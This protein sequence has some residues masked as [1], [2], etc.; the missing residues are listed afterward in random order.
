MAAGRRL[1]I[2]GDGAGRA[3]AVHGRWLD[4]DAARPDFVIAD[5]TQ[6][7]E[8]DEARI[9]AR[10]RARYGTA[11]K[12]GEIMAIALYDIIVLGSQQTVGAME[13]VL[14]KGLDFCREQG[15]DPDELLDAR[16]HP[17][18]L[19]FRFQMHSVIK[20]SVD[21]IECAKAG[22]FGRPPDTPPYDY[23]QL[24]AAIASASAQLKTYTA[25]EINA[26]Q[27]RELVFQP[28]GSKMLFNT[29]DFLLTFSLPNLHFH[30]TTAY[31]ILRGQGAPVG[32]RDYLGR[33]RVKA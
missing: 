3:G 15:R 29:E 33:M 2:G 21:A 23:A 7:L 22:F 28:G 9:D 32:K 4:C 26:L 19:P 12:T 5:A 24:Q 31:D 13:G 1:S 17:D 10:R 18:M 27:G 25:D 16:I 11:R 14:Q 30:A 6:R 20:H 8:S